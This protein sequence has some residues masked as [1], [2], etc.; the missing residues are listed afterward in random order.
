MNYDKII[1][2][3]MHRVLEMQAKEEYGVFMKLLEACDTVQVVRCRDC[4]FLCDDGSTWGCGWHCSCLAVNDGAPPDGFCA[5][6][7]R[8]E[9]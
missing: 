5:W 2:V 6:G 8:R 9:S 7:E 3:L 4:N 1:D